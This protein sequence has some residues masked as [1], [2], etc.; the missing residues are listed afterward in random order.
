MY[1]LS[2]EW[3]S[4]VHTWPNVMC[5]FWRGKNYLPRSLFYLSQ[6]WWEQQ[7]SLYLLKAMRG[8]WDA[9]LEKKRPLGVI[10][11][12]SDRGK[13]SIAHSRVGVRWPIITSS[14]II[15]YNA[16]IASNDPFRLWRKTHIT[17]AVGL[18]AKYFPSKCLEEQFWS[19]ELITWS[20]SYHS[21]GSL[22]QDGHWPLAQG[23]NNVFSNCYQSPSLYVSIYNI[24]CPYP[25]SNNLCVLLC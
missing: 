7:L 6:W 20:S 11:S 10:R 14:A 4:C 18:W 19:E 8:G 1:L 12:Q 24:P 21:C 17:W 22:R 2:T 5:H 23:G 25:N 13:S 15:A 9:H 3:E 16:I